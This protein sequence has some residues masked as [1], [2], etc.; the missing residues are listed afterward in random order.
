MNTVNDTETPRPAIQRR[1]WYRRPLPAVVAITSAG[2]VTTAA[3]G[4][5]AVT[6]ATARDLPIPETTAPVVVEVR[7][8]DT[9]GAAELLE[10]AALAAQ[11][12]PA[13]EVDADDFLYARSMATGL[14]PIGEQVEWGEGPMG[15]S[16]PNEFEVWVAQE[17]TGAR[18]LARENGAEW[19]VEQIDG[20]WTDLY[21]VQAGLPTEPEAFLTHI[22]DRRLAEGRGR[23][24]DHRAFTAMALLLEDG[25][26][27]PPAL[28]AA[29]YRAAALLPGA[30]VVEGVEDTAGRP[31]VAIAHE[32][33]GEGERVEWIFDP[34]T[35][36]YLG[37]R[38]LQITATS[39][40]EV[41]TVLYGQAV[42]DSGVVDEAGE[43]PAGKS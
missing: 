24:D 31:G 43:E 39:H 36:D 12:R 15:T 3:V 35:F 5:V 21:A 26:P 2:V 30:M 8:G 13:P 27:L 11:S 9:E 37:E 17:S 23:D 14:V 25:Q 19:T 7:P 42:L 20:S 28:E 33:A 22:R 32:D 40:I 6:G 10:R 18:G 29:V 34:E 38:R 4:L 16:G 41:G 1:P